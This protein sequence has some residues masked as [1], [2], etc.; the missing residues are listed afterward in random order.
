MLRFYSLRA[1]LAEN[2][3]TLAACSAFLTKS[4]VLEWDKPII[5]LL[6]VLFQD[7]VATMV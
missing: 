1:L 4:I 2:Q 5:L 7:F 3:G 6:L